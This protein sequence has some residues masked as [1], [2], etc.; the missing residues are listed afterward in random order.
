MDEY[1]VRRKKDYEGTYNILK[2]NLRGKCHKRGVPPE[3]LID[4]EG[5]H[6][7]EGWNKKRRFEVGL[8]S[9]VEKIRHDLDMAYQRRANRGARGL[10]WE[11]AVSEIFSG[12]EDQ[13]CSKSSLMQFAKG[14]LAWRMTTDKL[15][16]VWLEAI[17]AWTVAQNE[18]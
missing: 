15:Q 8:S 7:M 1:A 13:A 14:L 6:L 5:G 18:V 4:M 3:Q 12:K 16:C 9:E 2:E 11:K 10:T 17:R